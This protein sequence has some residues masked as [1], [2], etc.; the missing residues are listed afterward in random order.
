MNRV[1]YGDVDI[2]VAETGWPSA[3]DRDQMGV[4]MDNAATYNSNLVKFVNSGAGTPLMPNRT[5]ETYIF[6]LFNEDLKSSTSEKNFGIFL[7]D[8]EPVYN[9]GI[10]RD[11]QVKI[12]GF[13]SNLEY[14][15]V[16]DWI[17][18]KMHAKL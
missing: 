12:I 1:G 16:I 10:L 14:F 6:S 4:G 17:N 8:L 15:G 9:V 18:Y 13:L 11:P 3:G 2:V 5:F 7:P